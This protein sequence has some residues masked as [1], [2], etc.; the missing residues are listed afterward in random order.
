MWM[1]RIPGFIRLRC[2][3]DPT[4]TNSTLINIQRG[5][6]STVGPIIIS[7]LI[8][9]FSFSHWIVREELEEKKKEGG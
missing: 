3:A 5:Q 7:A 2:L 8:R 6:R 9:K 1:T 4:D